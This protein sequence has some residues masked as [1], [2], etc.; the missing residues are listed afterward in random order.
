V[1]MSPAGEEA[2]GTGITKDG[3]RASH[4]TAFFLVFSS[5]THFLHYIRETVDSNIL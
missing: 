2:A 4:A 1:T 3:G 5:F